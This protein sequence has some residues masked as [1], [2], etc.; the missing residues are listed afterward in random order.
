MPNKTAEAPLTSETTLVGVNV[1]YSG[2]AAQ[3]SAAVWGAFH[4][5]ID[6]I[7]HAHLQTLS[8]LIDEAQTGW[9]VSLSSSVK[10]RCLVEYLTLFIQLFRTFI[11]AN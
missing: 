11:K 10:L 9:N 1:T 5:L 8:V 4:P 6:Q 7:G 3:L 2:S